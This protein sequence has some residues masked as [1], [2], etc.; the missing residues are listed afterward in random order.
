MHVGAATTRDRRNSPRKTKIVLYWHRLSR[1][2]GY[3]NEQAGRHHER[4]ESA[5]I[6]LAFFSKIVRHQKI[7]G[8]QARADAET[9]IAAMR[10][11]VSSPGENRPH[12][13]NP[14]LETN[15]PL[16]ERLTVFYVIRN[17]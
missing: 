15:F 10:V 1:R 9:T 16:I 2:N 14:V 4:Y 7:S 5:Q 8:Q 6:I 3:S 11:K 13:D 12:P 17:I